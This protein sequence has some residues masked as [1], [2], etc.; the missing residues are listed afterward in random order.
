M[1]NSYLNI[2]KKFFIVTTIPATL[3]FFKGN[4]SFLNTYYHVCA[5]SS[6]KERLREIA[7]REGVEHR[8]IPMKRQISLFWDIVCLLKFLLLFLRERPDIVHGNT[9]KASMLSMVASWITRVPVRIYMCHGLR[10]Q[11]TSGKLRK[12]LMFMERLSCSCATEVICVS[13]GVRDTLVNNGICK[14][15]KAVV[16]G[17]GSAAG[18]DLNYFS[19]NAVKENKSIRQQLDISE[20]SFVFIFIG[21]IVADKG[22]DELVSTFSRLT[23]EG[24][25]LD[26]IIVGPAERDLN[27]ISDSSLEEIRKNKRIHAVGRQSDIRPYLLA[28]DTM[29]FPSYRE[30]F[31]MVLIEASAMGIPVIS[32]DI[33]GCNEIIMNGINGKLIPAKNA[34]AL[35]QEMKWFYEH[36]DLEVMQMKNVTREMVENRYEQRMVWSLL[37]TEYQ[38]LEKR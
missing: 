14:N 11:G 19:P 26:L 7:Q 4:L 20:K 3:N 29:V 9:P 1:G 10:Y 24:L 6:E 37:L 31:G 13:K 22:I 32:S 2:K 33:I 36:K 23:E 35:Y 12:L 28:S 8:E 16:V 21:R 17:H 38:R 34:E 30:G 5:I 18:I 27:P 25:D 15:E